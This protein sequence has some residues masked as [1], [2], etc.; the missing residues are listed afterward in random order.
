MDKLIEKYEENDKNTKK[1]LYKKTE[2]MI[3]NNKS[4]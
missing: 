2:L 1:K 3:L 4:E